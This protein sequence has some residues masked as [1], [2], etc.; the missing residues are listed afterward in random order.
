MYIATIPNFVDV[1]I[2]H[3]INTAMGENMQHLLMNRV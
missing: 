3:M 2:A 1:A